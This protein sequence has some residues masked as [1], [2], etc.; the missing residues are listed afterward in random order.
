MTTVYQLNSPAVFLEGASW[1]AKSL[2]IHICNCLVCRSIF[3]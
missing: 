1:A 2:F 3:R